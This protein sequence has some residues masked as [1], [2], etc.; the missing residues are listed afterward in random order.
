MPGV[1]LA[2]SA[3]TKSRAAEEPV[4]FKYRMKELNIEQGTPIFDFRR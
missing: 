3:D 1:H 4:I 2:L